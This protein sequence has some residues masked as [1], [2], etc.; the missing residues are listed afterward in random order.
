MLKKTLASPLDSKEIQLVHLKGKQSWIFNGRADAEVET[1][2]FGHLMR[3][4]DSFEK[5]MMLGKIEGG[6]RRG[7]QRMKWLASPTQWP[8]VWVNLGV[9]DG[10]GGLVCCSPWGCKESDTTEWLNWTDKISNIKCIVL[11]VFKCTVQ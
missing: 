11:T 7:Q 3:K 5:T 2:Y 4:T 10:Q 9:G 6:R 1:Q 8:W